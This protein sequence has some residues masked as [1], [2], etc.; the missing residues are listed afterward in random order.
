MRGVSH[1]QRLKNLHC[2]QLRL[3]TMADSRKLKVFLCHSKDDKHKVRDLYR[4]LISN[5]FNAWLDEEKLLP[6]QNWD[7]EIR[8]AI[9]ETDI[10]IAC[11]SNNSV[12][13]AGYVQKE[14]R[15]ALDVA[16]E[17]PEESIF[18]IPARLE[19]CEVPTR[20][21]KWQWVNFFKKNGYQKLS[22]EP[23]IST[24]CQKWR[25]TAARLG[26]RS[27]SGW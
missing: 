14:I 4:R 27:I 3:N 19:E 21:S 23:S 2:Q 17:Q 12:T 16:N 10:V 11:L 20:L 26:Q 22:Y 8:K 25:E 1:A 6:G 5:G 13:K 18:I 7:F 15:F 9:R 24:F